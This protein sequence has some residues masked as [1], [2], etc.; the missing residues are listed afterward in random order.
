MQKTVCLRLRGGPCSPLSGGGSA[1][2]EAAALLLPATPSPLRLVRSEVSSS[3]ESEE[4]S[5]SLSPET[6]VLSMPFRSLRLLLF[7]GLP[8]FFLRDVSFRGF[9][10]VMI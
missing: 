3:D 2:L 9:A 4:E 10:C 7:C 5:S 6:A 8:F 1:E